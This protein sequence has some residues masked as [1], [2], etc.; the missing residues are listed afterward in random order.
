MFWVAELLVD[1]FINMFPKVWT[2]NLWIWKKSNI[3]SQSFFGSN[4]SSNSNKSSYL[5]KGWYGKDFPNYS[6][7]NEYKRYSNR[8]SNIKI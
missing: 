4:S 7:E 2:K 5:S 3:W 1:G 6:W 8:A